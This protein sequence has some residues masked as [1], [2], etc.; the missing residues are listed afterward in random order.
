ML[1][2]RPAFEDIFS[3]NGNIY[4]TKVSIDL[5]DV[6]IGRGAQ[7]E[8]PMAG[9]DLSTLIGKEINVEVE[10]GVYKI[11]GPYK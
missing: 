10:E 4:I 8:S 3:L 6:I 2:M 1:K 7:M 11:L 9:F 5:N